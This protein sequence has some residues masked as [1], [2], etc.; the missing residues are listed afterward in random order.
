MV[1]RLLDRLQDCNRKFRTAAV[2]G[3]AGGRH[4]FSVNP[5]CCMQWLEVHIRRCLMVRAAHTKASPTCRSRDVCLAD[6]RARFTTAADGG[7]WR[8]GGTPAGQLRRHAGPGT[9]AAGDA[10]R[11]AVHDDVHAVG[12]SDT[13]RADSPCHATSA[14]I[15]PFS[16]GAVHII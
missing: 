5:P 13:G 7:G 14:H 16:Y 1:D 3:G 2:I 12:S 9:A 15:A 10:P 8:G 6:R 11:S 4:I